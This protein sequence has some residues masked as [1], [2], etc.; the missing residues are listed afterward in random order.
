MSIAWPK[1]KPKNKERKVKDAIN[2][3]TVPTSN[4]DPEAVL[5]YNITTIAKYPL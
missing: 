4:D 2:E 3:N 5:I 1:K